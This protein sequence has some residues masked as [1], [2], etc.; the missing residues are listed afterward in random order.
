MSL[1]VT[2]RFVELIR[3]AAC[4]IA[5]IFNNSWKRYPWCKRFFVTTKLWS[6]KTEM[7]LEILIKPRQHHMMEPKE[8]HHKKGKI[9]D[10]ERKIVSF[11]VDACAIFTFEITSTYVSC[12]V[13][14]FL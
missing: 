10:R 13:R 3:M 7:S 8:H 12:N 1:Y 5:F 4:R 2:F 14:F 9:G 11:I 6:L